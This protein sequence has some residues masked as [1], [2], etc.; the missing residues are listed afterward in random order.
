VAAS[1]PVGGRRRRCV[2]HPV[3]VG[4]REVLGHGVPEAQHLLPDVQLHLAVPRELLPERRHVFRRPD[5]PG[6]GVVLLRVPRRLLGQPVRLQEPGR[7]VRPGDGGH[8]GR[9]V[10]HRARHLPG[11]RLNLPVPAQPQGAHRLRKGQLRLQRPGRPSSARCRGRVHHSMAVRR[12]LKEEFAFRAIILSW[13]F[14]NVVFTRVV[15]RLSLMKYV[16]CGQ[17]LL[18]QRDLNDQSQK[19]GFGL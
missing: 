6:H 2:L 14:T 1:D 4:G 17:K 12:A 11:V 3:P 19:A 13:Y 10:R 7:V 9:R 5:A 16:L 15:G 8:H 18:F